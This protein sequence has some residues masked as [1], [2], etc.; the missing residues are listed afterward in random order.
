[1]TE[2]G[3]QKPVQIADEMVVPTGREIYLSLSA[4]GGG[5]KDADRDPDF[6]VIHSFWVPELFGKQDVMPGRTNHILFSMDTPGTYTG[7][8]AEFCGLQHGKMKF[9][10]VALAP[11]AWEDVG[12]TC[13]RCRR[14]PP[15]APLAEQGEE[16]FL[17][18]LSENRGSCTAC[19]AVGDVGGIAGPN[20][21][22]FADPT[23][24]VLRR[25]QLEHVP[26]KTARRTRKTLAGLAPRSRRGETRREDA[27]LPVERRRDRC[28][29]R[30]PLQLEVMPMSTTRD[31]RSALM[32]SVT[33]SA[34][35]GVRRPAALTGFWSWATTVDHK[36]IGIMYGFVAF[37]FFIVVASRPC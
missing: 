15:T 30:L 12:R 23:H 26:R 21:T 33:A 17:N 22:H 16:L 5:A 7:Q 8:C 18:P 28:P 10:V 6:Q 24:V 1:M 32:A 36:K 29:G 2:L 3:D 4:E 11:A 13:T 27:R 14:P 25:L 19:H 34:S 37:V 9:R 31:D 20:L 35:R